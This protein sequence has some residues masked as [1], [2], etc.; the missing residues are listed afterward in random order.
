MRSLEAVVVIWITVMVLMK[1]IAM[2]TVMK[3][4]K[5]SIHV[6]PVPQVRICHVNAFVLHAR[7]N[8]KHA[9]LVSH[10]M[11]KIKRILITRIKT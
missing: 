5:S 6:M 11:T 10:S 3:V 2:A 8:V 7:T 9:N 1:V 4:N